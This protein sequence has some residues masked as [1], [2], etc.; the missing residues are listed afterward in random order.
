MMLCFFC[1]VR[2]CNVNKSL[3]EQQKQHQNPKK[4]WITE[5]YDIILEKMA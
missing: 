2:L 3:K 5:I 4:R 1:S